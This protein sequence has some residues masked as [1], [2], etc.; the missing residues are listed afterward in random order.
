M[1]EHTGP[2]RIYGPGSFMFT[3]VLALIAL[4]VLVGGI[5]R[6]AKEPED[7]AARRERN[8]RAGW[9]ESDE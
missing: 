4:A 7:P 3:G 8:W 5:I 6:A 9:D 1:R 2:Y